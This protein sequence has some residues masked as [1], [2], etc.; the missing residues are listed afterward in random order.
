M[1]EQQH[2]FLNQSMIVN[3]VLFFI[4]IKYLNDNLTVKR[5]FLIDCKQSF[6]KTMYGEVYFLQTS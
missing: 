4:E 3:L 5:T 2:H 1:T 6:S